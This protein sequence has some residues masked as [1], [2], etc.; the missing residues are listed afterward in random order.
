MNSFNKTE[1][2]VF[3]CRLCFL[4]AFPFHQFFY[5]Q[6][7]KNSG[8]LLLNRGY[9]PFYFQGSGSSRTQVIGGF[10]FSGPCALD[11]SPTDPKINRSPLLKKSSIIW[12]L[13]ALCEKKTP[14]IE[15]NV[16]TYGAPVTLTFDLL[17][18]KSIGFFTQEGLSSYDV[19][20][21]WVNGYW[22]YWAE[23]VFTLRVTVTLTFDL[24]TPKSIEFL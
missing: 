12:S 10:Y 23:T 18:P 4:R 13:K 22:S 16:F 24:L 21:L 2:A 19:L 9:Y 3:A 8:V 7:P 14:V 11:L 5:Q 20:R 1:A 17:S 15:W 6:T